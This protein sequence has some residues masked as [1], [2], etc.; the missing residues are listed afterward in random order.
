MKTETKKSKATKSL[1]ISTKTDLRKVFRSTKK[2]L[3]CVVVLLA[4]FYVSHNWFQLMLI[5]GRSMEPSYHHMQLV[6]LDK[7]ADTY[8]YGDV[9]AF[10]SDGLSTVLVKRVAAC[11]G[12]TV[13]ITDGTLFVNGSKSPFYQSGAF[14]FSG[15][16]NEERKLPE[17]EYVV[18]GDNLT[19]SKDSRDNRVGCIKTADIIGKVFLQNN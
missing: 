16:L 5:Q 3:L 2:Y 10:H 4:A 18:L 12:D 7:R 17:G 9:I 13:V 6:V 11:P 8:Q 19:E 15:I 14:T 1:Q